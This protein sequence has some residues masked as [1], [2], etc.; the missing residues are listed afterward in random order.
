MKTSRRVRNASA[1]RGAAGQTSQTDRI[2]LFWTWFTAS[3]HRF[4]AAAAVS[5]TQFDVWNTLHMDLQ[6]HL[7]SIHPDMC[8][9]WE[10]VDGRRM[11]VIGGS[12][13]VSTPVILQTVAAAPVL[14]GWEIFA[15]RLPADVGPIAEDLLLFPIDNV[16]CTLRAAVPGLVLVV[17]TDL[18]F[19]EC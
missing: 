2:A 8:G 7:A 15:F 12:T 4:Q 9:E 10:V 5:R 14:P 19:R 3:A 17:A 11:L 1:K 18:T 13:L 16:W 6:D